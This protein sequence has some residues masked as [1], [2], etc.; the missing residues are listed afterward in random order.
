MNEK[1]LFNCVVLNIC[2]RDV[3]AVKA[4]NDVPEDSDEICVA[5]IRSV[6]MLP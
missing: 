1:Q 6:D 3:M 2:S 5:K 4:K